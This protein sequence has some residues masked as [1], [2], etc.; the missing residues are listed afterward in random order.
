MSDAAK[1]ILSHSMSPEKLAKRS[2][3]AFK[4]AALQLLLWHARRRLDAEGEVV[5]PLRSL[6]H[7]VL[8]L[9]LDLARPGG[10][11]RIRP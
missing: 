6:P 2:A 3:R 10:F 9:I 5:L 4:A 11:P 1:N 7:G 8:T